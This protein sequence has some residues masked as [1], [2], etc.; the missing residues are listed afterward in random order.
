MRYLQHGCMRCLTSFAAVRLWCACLALGMDIACAAFALP[1]LGSHTQLQLNIVKAHACMRVTC[2]F[3]VGHSMTNTNDHAR[4]LNE[5]DS[6][7]Q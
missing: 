1:T 4:I 6:Q 5:N 7:K 2:D 3:A